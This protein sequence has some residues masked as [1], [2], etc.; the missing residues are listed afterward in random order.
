LFSELIKWKCLCPS[1]I[2]RFRLK[3][4]GAPFRII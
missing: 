1:G 2:V 3:P 4:L